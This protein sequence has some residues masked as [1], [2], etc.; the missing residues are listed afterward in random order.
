[1]LKEKRTKLCEEGSKLAGTSLEY[2]ADLP[3]AARRIR[4]EADVGL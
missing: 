2:P 4:F 3:S 1:M